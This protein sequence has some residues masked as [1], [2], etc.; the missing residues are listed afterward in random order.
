MER[1]GSDD[2]VEEVEEKVEQGKGR[3]VEKSVNKGKGLLGIMRTIYEQ[4][5]LAGFWKGYRRTYI[6]IARRAH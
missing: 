5:G 4:R 6:F 3:D 1:E 2:E